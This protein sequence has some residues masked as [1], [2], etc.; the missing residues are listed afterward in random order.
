VR[1]ARHRPLENGARNI[2][3]T[4]T[5]LSTALNTSFFAESV[6]TFALVM[7]LALLLIG[8][9]FLVMIYRLPVETAEAAERR[10]TPARK[11]AAAGTT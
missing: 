10:K 4:G 6:A 2:W 8:I 5:A 3:V 11:V 1:C 7:G 9:G